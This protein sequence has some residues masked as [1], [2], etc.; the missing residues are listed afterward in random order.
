MCARL[1]GSRERSR[2]GTFIS[3]SLPPGR[4]RVLIEACFVLV[5]ERT[6]SPRFSGT[7]LVGARPDLDS[8]TF[9]S[10]QDIFSYNVEQSNGAYTLRLLLTIISPRMCADARIPP[11]FT[12]D[13]HNMIVVVQTQEQLD[14][15]SAVDYVGDLCL[16]CVDRF[17]TL[18]DALPSWGP[19]IDD[20]LAAYVAGLGD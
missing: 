13:T 14:L 19:A 6:S 2:H 5:V 10:L 8:R 15:Q 1:G 11:V 17:Q 16:G 4:V 18:R 12:G 7:L 3:V 9:S 20:Q